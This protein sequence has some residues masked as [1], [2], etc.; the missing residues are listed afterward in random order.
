MPASTASRNPHG[1]TSDRTEF[2][3]REGALAFLLTNFGLW[4]PLALWTAWKARTD[5]RESWLLIAPGLGLFAA[6]SFMNI[7]LS[8]DVAGDQLMFPNIVRAATEISSAG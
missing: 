3:G 6:S 5:S 4:L 2:I 1:I 7:T 8:P